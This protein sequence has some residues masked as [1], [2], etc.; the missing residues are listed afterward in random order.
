MYSPLLHVASVTVSPMGM[1]WQLLLG[2]WGN[3]IV[4]EKKRHNDAEILK[5]DDEE[6]VPLVRKAAVVIGNLCERK[7]ESL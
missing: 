2:G 4:R 6:V 3:W 1:A 7:H 5:L